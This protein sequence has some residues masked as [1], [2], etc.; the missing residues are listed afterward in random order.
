MLLDQ[1]MFAVNMK[2]GRLVYVLFPAQKDNL[3]PAIQSE[4]DTAVCLKLVICTVHFKHTISCV[5][6]I[7]S[8]L[9]KLAMC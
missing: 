5:L 7:L 9:F 2:A 1:I 4:T 6:E 3:I 8:N